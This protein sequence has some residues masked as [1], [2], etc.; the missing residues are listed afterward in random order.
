MLFEQ[1][2]RGATQP[3]EGLGQPTFAD[4][5]FIFVEGHV[6]AQMAAILDAPMTPHSPGK[7]FGVSS[8]SDDVALHFARLLTSRLPR[9]PKPLRVHAGPGPPDH[10]YRRYFVGVSFAIF[11]SAQSLLSICQITA[12]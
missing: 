10:S 9:H 4:T 7:Q 12:F 6:Q 2:Q 1:R 3:G 8:Q 5:A 11:L